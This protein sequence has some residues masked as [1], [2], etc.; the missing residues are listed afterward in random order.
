LSG[1][2]AAA[3]LG[4]ATISVSFDGGEPC[5]IWSERFAQLDIINGQQGDAFQTIVEPCFAEDRA[6]TFVMAL[7]PPHR[8]RHIQRVLMA[9]FG[10]VTQAAN[11]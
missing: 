7:K 9:V 5:L 1:S 3:S 4:Q 11:A 8:V 10:R 2:A 6:S